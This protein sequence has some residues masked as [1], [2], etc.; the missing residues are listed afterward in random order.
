MR[1]ADTVLHIGRSAHTDPLLISTLHSIRLLLH[2]QLR[3]EV[4]IRKPARRLI[5]CRKCLENLQNLRFP[6]F[7]ADALGLDA[8]GRL[9]T[10]RK[11]SVNSEFNEHL[12]GGKSDS[13]FL[14]INSLFLQQKVPN[15]QLI[16]YPDAAH[17]SLFQ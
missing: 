1:G 2:P 3:V 16:L 6:T 5:R 4:L 15:A 8:D 9:Q 11:G 7:V 17:G 13:I 14:T 12:V 10:H